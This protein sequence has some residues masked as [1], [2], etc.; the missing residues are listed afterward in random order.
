MNNFQ[1]VL[2]FLTAFYLINAGFIFFLPLIMRTKSDY[3]VIK[4]YI[5]KRAI[6]YILGLAGLALGILRLFVPQHPPIILGDLVPSVIM[7]LVGL[8]FLLGHI[9]YTKGI[10]QQKIEEG[11]EILSALQIPL[12]I[13]S[14]AGGVLHVILSGIP[15]F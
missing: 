13:I 12:G 15:L 14:F 3:D 8:T 5:Y 6:H 7:I 1:L 4:S 9:R 11:T 10:S 2:Y